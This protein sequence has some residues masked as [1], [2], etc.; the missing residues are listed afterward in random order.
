M[1]FAQRL[2]V[3]VLTA[4]LL[5]P[6]LPARA[7]E[8]D[9]YLPDDAEVVLS[10]NV[11]QILDAPLLQKAAAGALKSALA[12]N[13]DVQKVL[14]ALGF[15]PL[16][17]VNSVTAALTGVSADAKGLIIV[18]GK[19]NKAKFEAQAEKYAREKADAIK[20]HAAGGN[21]IFEFKNP[22]EESKE[23]VFASLLSDSTLVLSPSKEPVLD[24]LA[25][26][27]GKKQGT[28]KKDLA[29]LIAK[30]DAKQSMWFVV[31][32]STLAKA[33]VANADERAKKTLGKIQSLIGGAHIDKDIKLDLAI[34]TKDAAAAKEL[35]DE[36]KEGLEQA[37]QLLMLF[38]GQEP[39]LQPV[40][41]MVNN[42]KT[43]AEGSTVTIKGEMSGKSL[44]K[45]IDQ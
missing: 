19:M 43:T 21:K 23:P 4:A 42:L 41:D 22:N 1:L 6:A 30:A 9:K 18:H 8:P 45:V 32:G 15:D 38:A 35:V 24:A 16:K 20:V 7:A 12:G 33:D 37:K 36:I 31:P 2:K 25:K 13:P 11:R 26:A 5:V 17:D 10:V 27:A 34:G 3:L 39:K 40:V 29:D 28:V 44:E 14:E